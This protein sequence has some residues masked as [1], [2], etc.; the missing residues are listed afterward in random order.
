M[1]TFEVTTTPTLLVIDDFGAK[2][3]ASW[4]TARLFTNGR[5]L[6]LTVLLVT[7]VLYHPH[8][9]SRTI[10]SNC[11]YYFILPS[12]R[13]ESQLRTLGGQLNMKSRILSA[14][15]TAIEPSGD[16]ALDEHR[17]LLLDLCST[18]PDILRVRSHIHC[19]LQY[20]YE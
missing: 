20:A 5:H 13:L 15:K 1:D 8:P 16:E 12:V 7:H 9:A 6:G 4:E 17:Y 18:T 11:S 19:P 2:A 14:Y 10:A 3:C